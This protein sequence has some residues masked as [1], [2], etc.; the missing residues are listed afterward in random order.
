MTFCVTRS[1]PQNQLM[2][3][4]LCVFKISFNYQFLRKILCFCVQYS[5]FVWNVVFCAR[6]KGISLSIEFVGIRHCEIDFIVFLRTILHEIDLL[7]WFIVYPLLCVS[8]IVIL[9]CWTIVNNIVTERACF[10]WNNTIL[11]QKLFCYCGIVLG[12]SRKT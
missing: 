1:H 11:T 10:C 6:Q 3:K 4:N 8:V 2:R 5:V 7:Y 9:V 12:T